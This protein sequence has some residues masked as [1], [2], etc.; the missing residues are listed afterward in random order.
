[1]PVLSALNKRS[2]FEQ[3]AFY[4]ADCLVS[5][6]SKTVLREEISRQI[7]PRAM[8][9]LVVLCERAAMVVSA[10]EL[11]Q[12][13][14]G[15]TLFGDNP[16][17]KV[18]AQLRHVLGDDAKAPVYIETIR[19]RGYRIVATVRAVAVGR[20][21]NWAG[22]SPFRGLQAFVEEYAEVFFGRDNA[23]EQLLQTVK[24]SVRRPQALT[25]VLGPSGSGK[26][27]LIR[28]GLLPKLMHGQ[29]PQA[30]LQ[31]VSVTM[32]DL[33]DTGD[34]PLLTALGSALIDW[35]IAGTDVFAGAS[36]IS[37]GQRL[38]DDV[39]SVIAH[40]QNTLL[41]QALAPPYR[42]LALFVDRY[43]AVFTSPHVSVAARGDFIAVLD[44]F[45]R[46][47]AVL[48]IVACRN[49]FY[50]YIAECP[51]LMAGKAHGAHFDLTPPTNA[52]IAQIIRLPAQAANLRFA[53]DAHTQARLDDVLC[54]SALGRPDA[55]PLLQYTLQ[56]LYRLRSDQDEL[57][58]AAFH[59]L[60]GVEGALGR[61]ADEVL[62]TLSELQRGLLPRIL[63]LLVA[64]SENEEI[65]TSVR[66]PW[67]AL[68]SVAERELVTAFVEARLFVSELVG[69]EAGFG[70]AHEALLRRWARV[71][72]W[73]AEHR[74]ALRVRSRVALSASRWFKEKHSPDLLLPHGKQLHEARAL[75]KLGSFSLS[76]LEIGYIHASNAKAR[77]R[78]RRRLLVLIALLS[79]TV[80]AIGLGLSAI[81]AKQTA[82]Q[83]RHEAEGLMEFM[84]GDF[85][86]KLRPLGRLDLLDSIS[87]KALEYLSLSDQE[88]SNSISQTQRAKALEVIAEV[89][90]ARGNPQLA[91]HALKNSRAIL[92][93]QL[94]AAHNNK[95][96]LKQLGVN[97]FWQGQICLDQSDWVGAEGFFKQYQ[98]YSDRLSS[99]DPGNVA[100]WIEQS[101]AHNNLGTLALK[102]GNPQ[103]AAKEFLLSV[104]LKTR[105]LLREPEQRVVAAELADSLSWLG[106]SKEAIGELSEALQMYERELHITKKLSDAAPGD[107]LWSNRVSR[108]LQHR[109]DLALALGQENSALADYRQSQKI[110]TAI[111]ERE[112]SNRVWQSNR[113]S[114]Q[115]RELQILGYRGGASKLLP[116]L[117]HV[118]R[119]LSSMA[120]LDPTKSL[121][122]RLEATAHRNTAVILLDI[123][124]FDDAKHQID[125]SLRVL[126][127]LYTKN[128]S[129]FHARV[130]FVNALL[131]ASEIAAAA[132]DT[133]AARVACQKVEALIGVDAPGKADFRILDPWVRAQ[134]C[135][136]Q[137]KAVPNAIA[138]LARMGYHEFAYIR[139]ISQLK[140]REKL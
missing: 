70:V 68:H 58:F 24:A 62:S 27:S 90:I 54:A 3:G 26:T 125:V 73:I 88:V 85:A 30:S 119:E 114:A 78:E 33:A 71:T 100:V 81:A 134:L 66:V 64:L 121:L 95:T 40:L 82:Q 75:L 98:V 23:I 117:E 42:R 74:E 79:L 50:P 111:L 21:E 59:Q 51:F 139:S 63:S 32:L 5:P 25:V 9:V 14:W 89:N 15:T 18:I 28:A 43:E 133:A 131:L 106:S 101:Y 41:T 127:M 104:D 57:S 80:L 140:I 84:L 45:A 102:R 4:L 6:S 126:E 31:L 112:P 76:Q 19:K 55:L 37:L 67:S 124:H 132:G 46:S 94:D 107:A 56:E 49:D 47:N 108:A 118:T 128:Q 115:L 7:E 97:A 38:A 52:D 93:A 22:K 122:L 96:I 53:V 87:A 48:L 34:Q 36:S 109:A 129:D 110:L 65:V 13:C 116:E 130:A 138:E 35:Q 92:L 120:R 86:D 72:A 16:V 39:M 17:H 137:S 91:L 12:L 77:W 69:Q 83:R 8:D 103:A 61:R 29:G 99:L 135:L 10:E 11:L 123:H 2:Y 20:Q 105:A 60:G 136:G 113:L 1:M 44:A